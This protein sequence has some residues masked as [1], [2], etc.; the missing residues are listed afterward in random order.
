M[1]VDPLIELHDVNKY[2][3][4]SHVLQDISLTVGTGEVV[5]I[6]GPS[7]PGRSTLHRTI[8]RLE[9]IASGTI[10]LD[11]RPLPDGGEAL[12][13]LRAEAGLVSRRRVR[14]RRPHRRGAHPRGVLHRPAQ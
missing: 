2:L 12:A 14:A 1:A 13:R 7:G 4:E 9:T 10:E 5:V 8:N 6:T 3:G 11:G